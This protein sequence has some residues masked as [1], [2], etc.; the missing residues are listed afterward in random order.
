M[1]AAETESF[2]ADHVPGYRTKRYILAVSGGMDSMV[3]LDVFRRL[4]LTIE[5]AHCNFGLRGTESD[6]D[7][8]FVWEQCQKNNIPCHVKR[9]D[10]LPEKESRGEGT[11]LV[12]RRLRYE[13]FEELRENLG[14]DFIC[15]GHHRRD[16]AETIIHRFMKGAFPESMQGIK[17]ANGNILRPMI[18]ITYTSLASY[19]REH[20]LL[21]RTDSSNLSNDYTRNKIRHIL[22]PAFEETLGANSEQNI[23]SI[24]QHYESYF[25]LIRQQA[26]NLLNRVK[27]WYEIRV[28]TLEKTKG[29]TALLYEALK[30]FGFNW[31]QCA[32][33]C[34]DLRR[35]QGTM[36][37]SHDRSVRLYFAGDIL[38][39][40]EVKENVAEGDVDQKVIQEKPLKYR[41]DILYI[42]NT[43]ARG[44]RI[45]IRHRKDGDMFTPL[46]MS[47]TKSVADF[48]KDLKLSPAEKHSC[49][50]LCI[51]DRIAGIIGLRI[52]DAFKITPSTKEILV[53]EEKRS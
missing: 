47:G 46:G 6:A 35:E 8:S 9:F 7:A 2:L 42:D 33:I 10:T 16:N 53:I 40:V 29:N 23:T 48:L 17:P 18:K 19:A 39:V 32:D 14:F 27:G 11:Q 30:N 15:T 24:A 22:L 1:L 28:D 43:L 26:E 25:A 51:D 21:F 38:Q 41:K 5:V 4:R 34:K 49:K 3:M 12:A 31:S 45:T 20:G 37:E 44:H 36:Y 13:W 50:V 52:D